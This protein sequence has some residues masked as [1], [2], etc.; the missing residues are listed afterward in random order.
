MKDRTPAK[1]VYVQ[2]EN[3]EKPRK[4]PATHVVEEYG[5]SRLIVY[6]GKEIVARFISGV[7]NWWTE[8]T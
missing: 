3:E 5:G 4:I 7:R 2:L 6:D 8:E 1:V